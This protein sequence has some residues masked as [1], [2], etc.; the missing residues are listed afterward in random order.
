MINGFEKI[1]LVNRLMLAAKSFIKAKNRTVGF[2]A[3]KPIKPENM[4][5]CMN[6]KDKGYDALLPK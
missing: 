5:K 6:R 1:Q 4:H 2:K 3:S